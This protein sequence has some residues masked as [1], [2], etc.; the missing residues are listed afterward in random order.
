LCETRMSAYLVDGPYLLHPLQ[1]RFDG[2][3]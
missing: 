2:A 1:V 3:V